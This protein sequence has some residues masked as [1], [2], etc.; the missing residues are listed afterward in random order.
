MFPRVTRTLLK[1]QSRSVY[2]CI[3]SLGVVI[4]GLCIATPSYAAK[5]VDIRAV[6]SEYL[7]I[8]WLDGEVIYGDTGEGPTAFMGHESRGAD[9]VVSYV[10]ALNTTVA[11]R[12]TAYEILSTDDTRYSEWLEPVAVHRRAKVN[13]IAWDWPEPPHTLEHIVFVQMPH[14]KNRPASLRKPR[15]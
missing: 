7:M 12:T 15:Y 5:L 1:L 13:G 14:A 11:S 4:M 10:P 2:T 8:T 3:L 9:T 6:D